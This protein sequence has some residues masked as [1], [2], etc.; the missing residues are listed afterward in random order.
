MTAGA[1]SARSERGVTQ[2]MHHEGEVW[3]LSP[4][5]EDST[6]Q[7]KVEGCE[8]LQGGRGPMSES[9][10]GLKAI[11]KTAVTWG[12]ALGAVSSVLIG[13]YVLVV[14][15]PGVHSLPERIGEA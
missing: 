9:S 4:Q 10:R 5:T 13:A 7:Y 8:S 14:P 1:T 2:R 6:L 3:S 11:L 12:F 15:G